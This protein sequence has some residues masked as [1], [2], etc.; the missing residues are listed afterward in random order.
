M[1]I[2]FLGTNSNFIGDGFFD[3]NDS[4]E[5]LEIDSAS[6]TELVI[7][8]PDTGVFTTLSGVGLTYGLEG[9]PTGGTITSMT[10]AQDGITQA[11]I[12]NISINLP[13]LIA[14]FD[15]IDINDDFAQIIAIF[16]SFPSI[17]F[18]ASR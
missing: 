10:F 6:P 13:A 2:T 14:A 17:T 7:E 5:G 12:T 18:D 15:A 4:L 16:N 9:E 1:L 8:N 3:A 11:T